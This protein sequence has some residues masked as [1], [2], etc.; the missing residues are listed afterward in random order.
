[1]RA[2]WSLGATVA[3]VHH[4]AAFLFLDDVVI[5][6]PP[7]LLGVVRIEHRHRGRIGARGQSTF[8]TVVICDADGRP[9][10]KFES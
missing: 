8:V 7:I 1:M 2:S 6:S 5:V 3:L 10:M 4:L 9:K